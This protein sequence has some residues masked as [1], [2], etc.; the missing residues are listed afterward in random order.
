MHAVGEASAVGPLFSVVASRAED[1]TDAP[2]NE[3]DRR[4]PSGKPDNRTDI[5]DQDCEETTDQQNEDQ[6]R[7]VATPIRY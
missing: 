2:H 4:A 6:D 1:P 7:A 5:R 3:V